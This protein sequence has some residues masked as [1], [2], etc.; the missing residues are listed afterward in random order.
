MIASLIR[1]VGGLIFCAV[2][3]IM[4]FGWYW[5]AER[6]GWFAPKAPTAWVEQAG[7]SDVLSLPGHRVAYWGRPDAQYGLR[8]T[9]RRSK[10]RA[11]VVHFTHFPKS[12]H[13]LV[14]YGHR[15]DPQ[16]G[17][18]SFGYHFYIDWTGRIVQGAPLSVRTN[19]I[20]PPH[21]AQRT[22]VARK[23]WSGNAI[24]I[25]LVGACNALRAPTW[26]AWRR[27]ARETPTSAQ[28]AAGMAVIDALRARYA[29]P[30]RAVY[31]HGELQTDRRAF[32]GKTLTRQAR[33]ACG[34]AV[35]TEERNAA[36][37][38]RANG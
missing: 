19:H 7:R 8:A 16:R 28:L 35:P 3:G 1:F 27:C 2:F 31:G 9:K 32:E 30:C 15:R 29:I 4:L 36:T 38:A 26:G 22:G 5:M 12:L 24:G 25:T 33:R 37:W 14:Q 23:V 10:P 21:R 20:K 6:S 11:I 17:N 34:T 18:A 13:S